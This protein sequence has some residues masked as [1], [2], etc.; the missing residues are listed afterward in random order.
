MRRSPPPQNVRVDGTD[1]GP[2]SRVAQTSRGLGLE[3]VAAPEGVELAPDDRTLRPVKGVPFATHEAHI[4]NDGALI[5]TASPNLARSIRLPDMVGQFDRR[6][7]GLMRVAGAANANAGMLLDDAGWRVVVLPSLG[8]LAADLGPG[9]VA[10]RADGRR[11]AV[12][13]DGAVFE[14]AIPGAETT[15]VEL[16]FA[17]G[18]I[19]YAADGT[20]LAT[21]G[22]GFAG[23][24]GSPIVSL[25]C[26]SASPRALARHGDGVFS[27]WDTDSR[28]RLGSWTPIILGPLSMGLSAGGELASMG[29]PFAEPAAACVARSI[30]G[31]LVRYVEGARTIALDPAGKGLLVGGEW[32]ALWLEPPR[33]VE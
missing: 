10:L 29:T 18:A 16:D 4:V 7:P 25:T 22:A 9:P 19:A 28:T 21:N 20:L 24:D 30:D 27:L 12:V 3:R 15:Q 26:A 32:G 33:E 17:P 8:D 5:I 31:A 2:W 14:L 11:A 23:E 6:P 1:P 13:H